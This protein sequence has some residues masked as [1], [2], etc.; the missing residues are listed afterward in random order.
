MTRRRPGPLGL[1]GGWFV[2]GPVLD[3]WAHNKL[4]E[5]EDLVV[6]SWPVRRSAATRRSSGLENTG[7][8]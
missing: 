5:M 1:L 2:V 7:G 8:R 3:A 4:T 6:P